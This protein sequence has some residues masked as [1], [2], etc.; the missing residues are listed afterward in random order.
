MRYRPA[1]SIGRPVGQAGVRGR[2][3]HG[4]RAQRAVKWR[5]FGVGGE[6]YDGL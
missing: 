4:A 3:A 6:G 5:G 1:W 2:A